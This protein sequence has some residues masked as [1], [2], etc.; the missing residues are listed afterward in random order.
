MCD[1][2]CAHG[3]DAD[4]TLQAMAAA[5]IAFASRTGTTIVAEGIETEAEL[6]ALLDLGVHLGQ[7]YLLGRP[8]PD[9]LAEKAG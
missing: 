3:I 2:N 8:S 7:G 5:F 9:G 1:S 6:N 4:A